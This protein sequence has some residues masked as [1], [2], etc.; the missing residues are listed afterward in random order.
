[1]TKHA[2]EVFKEI[3]THYDELARL[4]KDDA[5]RDAFQDTVLWMATHPHS[6]GNF[7]RRFRIRFHFIR[8]EN[9]RQSHVQLDR[10]VADTSEPYTEKTSNEY[11]TDIIDEIRNAILE[12]E[13]TAEK[14]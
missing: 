11:A 9:L 4:I 12:E 5:D 1:M 14:P 8:I 2:D 10:D 6:G 13:S 3:T 7:V